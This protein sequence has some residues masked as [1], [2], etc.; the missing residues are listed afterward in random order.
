MWCIKGSEW[1]T[2]PMALVWYFKQK[3][4]F[5][6]PKGSLSLAIAS[7]TI[8][9]ANRESRGSCKK[10]WPSSLLASFFWSV[11]LNY[12][13]TYEWARKGHTTIAGCNVYTGHTARK[14]LGGHGS[15]DSPSKLGC[16]CDGH[17]TAPKCS[18]VNRRVHTRNNN[19]RRQRDIFA[20][21][22]AFCRAVFESDCP[23]RC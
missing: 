17:G 14:E 13:Y 1:V 9:I 20:F 19:G 8:S 10:V 6:D 4:G 11:H 23:H 2:K 22:I 16:T 3:D 15:P 18:C 21:K 12:I 5:P 7:R